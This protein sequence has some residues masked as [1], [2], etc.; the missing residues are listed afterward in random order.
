MECISQLFIS[1]KNKALGKENKA[2]IVRAV[3]QM[4]SDKKS[5]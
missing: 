2:G 4:K 5:D 3:K 1:E